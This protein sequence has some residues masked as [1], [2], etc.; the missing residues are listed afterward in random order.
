MAVLQWKLG[1]FIRH[2][3][4]KLQPGYQIANICSHIGWQQSSI[5]SSNYPH[6]CV[7]AGNHGKL[8]LAK[9]HRNRNRF[10]WITFR[11]ALIHV[12]TGLPCLK[13]LLEGHPPARILEA[14]AFQVILDVWRRRADALLRVRHLDWTDFFNMSLSAWINLSFH[15]F[16]VNYW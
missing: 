14:W 5:K 3:W 15:A 2:N 10:C 1:A 7:R 12:S 9:R 4:Y 13:N 16:D 8:F 11:I 6:I